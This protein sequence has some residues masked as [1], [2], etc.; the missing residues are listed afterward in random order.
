MHIDAGPLATALEA[1][2]AVTE[3]L[4]G[5]IWERDHTVWQ[6]DPTE[7]ADRLGWL[8]CPTAMRDRL[9]RVPGPGRRVRADGIS[10]CCSSGMGGSSLYPEVLATAFPP[11]ADGMSLTVLDSTHPDAVARAREAFDLSRT[12]LVVSSKSGSTIET[13]SHLER[14]G[15]TW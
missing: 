1:T 7:V 10:T 12:L 13:R 11:P 9:R 6:D 2:V 14:F 5:R 15:P 3:A 8:D 4:I